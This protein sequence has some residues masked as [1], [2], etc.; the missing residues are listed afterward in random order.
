MTLPEFL[1][2]LAGVPGLL[3]VVT[4]VLSLRPHQG[5]SIGHRRYAIHNYKETSQ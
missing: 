5:K 1:S 2:T 4:S 3:F